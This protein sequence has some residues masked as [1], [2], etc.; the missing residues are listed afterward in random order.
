MQ[1]RQNPN[2]L[3]DAPTLPGGKYRVDPLSYAPGS[4]L[5]LP[6]R[7]AA[8]R[9]GLESAA[10]DAKDVPNAS[11]TGE[12]QAETSIQSSLDL[13]DRDFSRGLRQLPLG[14][15]QPVILSNPTA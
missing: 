15:G 6:N 12:R 1:P 10:T 9:R 5:C 8:S 3:Q 14:S 4:G 7:S 11:A 13:M 2:D